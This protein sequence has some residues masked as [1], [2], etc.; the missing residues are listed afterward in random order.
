MT[1]SVT[2]YEFSI[3]NVLVGLMF[4]ISSMG[5]TSRDLM[6]LALDALE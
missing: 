3:S 6:G 4:C 1:S 5:S 2:R